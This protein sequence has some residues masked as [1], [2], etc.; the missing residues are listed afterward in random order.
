MSLDHLIVKPANEA[1]SQEAIHR[2]A[3]YWGDRVGI[4]VDEYLKT[5]AV[6]EQGAFARDGKLKIW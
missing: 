4:T 6:F 5:F 1:Q 2:D 3:A